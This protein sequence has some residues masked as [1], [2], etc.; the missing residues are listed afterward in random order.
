MIG[1]LPVTVKLVGASGPVEPHPA[2]EVGP[3]RALKGFTDDVLE[4]REGL[5]S[6]FTNHPKLGDVAAF[7]QALCGLLAAGH[8]AAAE[9]PPAVVVAASAPTHEPTAAPQDGTPETEPVSNANLEALV[10]VLTKTI[11]GLAP[12]AA[13][14]PPVDGGLDRNRPPAGSVVV[15]GCGLGLP[16]PEKPVMDPQNVDRILRGEQLIDLLPVRFRDLMARKHVTRVVKT[17]EGDGRFET[18]EDS[19]D[20]LKLAGRPGAFD[21]AAEYGVPEKLVE[22]L[23]STTQLA[24]AAGIDALREAGIP[25]VQRWRRTSKGT[26]LPDRWMLPESMRDETGV[27]FASAFPGLDRFAAGVLA[28]LEIPRALPSRGPAAWIAEAWKGQIRIY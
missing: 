26:F 27:V 3:K 2:I 12:A 24:M 23:D 11:A 7:N 1:A 4:G 18:I 21:L 9:Q 14:R 20:V 19:A 6:L 17:A 16:G 28:A 10:Q 22:A 8:G 25:L 15:T 5:V 13:A